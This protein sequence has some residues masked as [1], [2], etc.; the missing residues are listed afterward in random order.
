MLFKFS[1]AFT[2]TVAHSVLGSA[3]ALLQE[4]EEEEGEETAQNSFDSS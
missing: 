1:K 2:V 4:E 3:R